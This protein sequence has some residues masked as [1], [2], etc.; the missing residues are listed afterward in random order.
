MENGKMKL[1]YIKGMTMV[2]SV[3]LA[4]SLI[5]CGSKSAVNTEQ[6]NTTQEMATTQ[7]SSN[8]DSM[9][10][11]TESS[12]ENSSRLEES[13]EVI[14]EGGKRLDDVVSEAAGSDAVQEEFENSL[15]NFIDL[16]DFINGEK[17]IDGI[18]Y[19]EL[20]DSTKEKVNSAKNSLDNSLERIHPNYKSDFKDW[21]TDKA[22]SALDRLSDI[23]DQ[24]LEIWDEIKSKRKQK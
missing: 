19:D 3:A 5:G 17:Q 6:T 16:N 12:S 13:L 1:T 14:L 23:K 24:G 8:L 22:A 7:D 11:S 2:C 15:Q 10:S 4:A 21:F 9:D 20:S 18:S